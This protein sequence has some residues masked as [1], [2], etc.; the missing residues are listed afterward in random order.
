MA[1]PNERKFA[2]K[3]TLDRGENARQAW[4]RWGAKCYLG[5]RVTQSLST[6]IVQ[7]W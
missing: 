1:N 3:V 7:S 4:S 2:G 6:E 5:A